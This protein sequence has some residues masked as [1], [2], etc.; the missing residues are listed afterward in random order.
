[1]TPTQELAQAAG[2]DY[3]TLWRAV[4]FAGRFVAPDAAK[5]SRSIDDDP[6]GWWVP[7]HFYWGMTVRNAL[8]SAGCGEKELGCANLDDIYVP[9][10]EIAVTGRWNKA[11]WD[12]LK[13]KYG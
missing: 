11:A 6:D 8:R 9:I 12:E 13:E 2:V 3:E 4:L 1:M 7:Y 5:I 10:V